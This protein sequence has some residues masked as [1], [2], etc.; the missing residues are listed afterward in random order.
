M[1]G[2]PILIYVYICTQIIVTKHQLLALSSKTGEKDE[3]HEA[4]YKVFVEYL[5]KGA[6]AKQ[7]DPIAKGLMSQ[8][9]EDYKSMPHGE[10]GEFFTDTQRGLP[11]FM[12]K[13]LHFCM[14]GISP[15]DKEKIDVLFNFYYGNRVNTAAFYY[16]KVFGKLFNMIERPS[17]KSQL[18]AVAKIYKESP[19]LVAMPDPVTSFNLSSEEVAHM[20]IPI[21]SIAGTVGPRHIL[22]YSMGYERMTQHVESADTHNID[23]S[24]LWDNLDLDDIAE[25]QRYIYEICRLQ[26]PVG[27]TRKFRTFFYFSKVSQKCS[28]LVLTLSNHDASRILYILAFLL[29]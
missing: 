23:V 9:V 27:Q 4:C 3:M 7:N 22:R 14:F 28:R 26:T 13:Y 17:F 12:I 19:S 1:P 24:K 5:M 11:R 16:P 21:M 25:V 6:L 10:G 8:L 15:T 2:S 29:E 20:V 18:P